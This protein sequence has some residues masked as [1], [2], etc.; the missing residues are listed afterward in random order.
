MVDQVAGLFSLHG[1]HIACHTV[2]DSGPPN[3]YPGILL[4]SEPVTT[5]YALSGLKE[6]SEGVTVASWSPVSPFVL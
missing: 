6:I 2:R 3:W 4:E 5:A 1:L